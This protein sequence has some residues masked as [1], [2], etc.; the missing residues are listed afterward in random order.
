[1]RNKIKEIIR[2]IKAS[3]FFVAFSTTGLTSLLQILT[4]L[5]INKIIAV[6]IGPSGIAF[7]GQFANFRDIMTNFG[8]GSFGQGVTKYVAD[9]KYDDKTIISTSLIFS[10]A[11]SLVIG[12]LI[13]IFSE[14]LSLLLFNTI[15]YQFI[16]YIFSF[17]I[18][19]YSLNNLLLSIV[20]GKRKFGFLAKMKSLNSIVSLIVSSL[21]CWYFGLEG[22]L[23]AMSINTSLVFFITLYLYKTSNDKF[24]DFSFRYWSNP[25]IK[26]LLG[27]TL[28]M[29]TAAL[30]KPA[31]EFFL[32]NHIINGSGINDA[33]LWES[34]MKISLYY[35]QIITVGLGVYY[36]PKLSSLDSDADI[37]KELFN[38]IKK[39]MP[40][41]FLIATVL[42][43]LRV[44][45]IKLLFSLEFIGMVDLFMPQ[46]ICDF[47]MVFSFLLAYIMLAKAMTL[48]FVITQI[49]ISFI[50]VLFSVW[51]Y[52]LAGIEG[53][54][55]ASA[56]TYVFY[57]I[58]MIFIFRKILFFKLN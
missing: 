40:L 38:G 43:S 10:F 58:M 34:M 54:I 28:M 55:W 56:L 48:V 17:T 51:L 31:V 27:F 25:V 37:K 41:Y 14:N 8:T 35:T 23:I 3:E 32:R 29:I 24:I 12:S 21:L 1:M 19:F 20:N 18:T 7:L 9:E 52:S 36:L 47:F 5:V 30:L 50:R 22:A 49:I 15:E 42:Y 11:T 44:L 2:K 57:A 4:G 33:G 16:F 45:V 6:K 26:K 46:L 53:I 13:L 39:I